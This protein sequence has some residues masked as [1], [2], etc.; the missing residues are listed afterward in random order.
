M[1]VITSHDKTLVLTILQKIFHIKNEGPL[2]YKNYIHEKCC[3]KFSKKLLCIIIFSKH[4]SQDLK[5]RK[6]L[7]KKIL[8]RYYIFGLIIHDINFFRSEKGLTARC[9]LMMMIN[10]KKFFFQLFDSNFL[11]NDFI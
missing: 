3:Y 7:F 9:A 5:I 11:T 6:K 10:P 4:S 1:G 2:S 8:I